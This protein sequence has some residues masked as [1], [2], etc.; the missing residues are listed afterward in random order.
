MAAKLASTPKHWCGKIESSS[1]RADVLTLFSFIYVIIPDIG[2]G[3][4][5]M[6]SITGLIRYNPTPA[7]VVREWKGETKPLKKSFG[8]KI[9]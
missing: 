7:D 6:K 4:R 9:R 8:R 1:S 5:A 3:E 2:K